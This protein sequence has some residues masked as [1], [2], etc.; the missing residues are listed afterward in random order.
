MQIGSVNVE[1]GETTKG[2]LE[3]IGRS[4]GHIDR[5]PVMAACGDRDGDCLWVVANVH[6][7][8][9][10]GVEVTQRL[11][12]SVSPENLDGTLVCI[13]SI[14]ISGFE[15]GTRRSGYDHNDPN[16]VY[17]DFRNDEKDEDV[18]GATERVNKRLFD[19]ID[20]FA[21]YLIDLHSW[22]YDSAPFTI[23]HRAFV[24]DGLPEPRAQEIKD[25]VELMSKAVGF[26]SLKE[27]PAEE[28]IEN[29]YHRSLASAALNA[30]KTPAVTIELGPKYNILDENIGT[31]VKGIRH[32]M[33]QKD[34]L[35]KE[36]DRPQVSSLSNMDLQK[37]CAR[38]QRSGILRK[39]VST[40]TEFGEDDTLC[41][42]L[43][44]FGE[45]RHEVT[46]ESDGWVF[47]FKKGR[48]V[49]EGHPV[50]HYGRKSDAPLVVSLPEN[51]RLE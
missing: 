51:Y 33:S 3:L 41:R 21:D 34:I 14:N 31:T 15:S 36:S 43:D 20:E 13:P 35:K 32:Y 50:V 23:K 24:H 8:E 39:A 40:G 26:T 5:A 22:G 17:P 27:E 12:S 29:N 10:A 16:R 9:T 30:A 2:Y 25:E 46:A 7:N 18:M 11:F 45:K 48:S 42:I 1:E 28:I 37:A 6:G 47:A 19:R 44:L 4:T 38:S 49:H